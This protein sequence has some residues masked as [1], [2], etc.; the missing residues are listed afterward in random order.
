MSEFVVALG[1][2][3]VIEGIV[4]AGFPN[5][6]K[7]LAANAMESPETSLRLAGIAS[8]VIGLLLIWL[9]RG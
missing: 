2:V 7:R 5:A 9:V 3:L 6:A 4:F 8:A 1:L